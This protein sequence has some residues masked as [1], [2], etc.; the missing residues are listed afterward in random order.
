MEAL[1]KTLRRQRICY[2]APSSS[3]LWSAMDAVAPIGGASNNPLSGIA[4]MGDPTA[5]GLA[6][7]GLMSAAWTSTQQRLTFCGA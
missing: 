2:L 6:G 5:A 3:M 7:G 4:Q 1:L